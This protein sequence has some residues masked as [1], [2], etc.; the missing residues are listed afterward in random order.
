[1]LKYL[2]QN[3]VLGLLS[4]VLLTISYPFSGGITPL[5]FI[6]WIP[7]FVVALRLKEQE[8]G[9]FKFFLHGYLTTFVFNLGTTWWIWNSTAGGALMAFICNSLLM[10]IALT[11]GFAFFKRLKPG[12]FLAGIG[13]L[14]VC[15]EFLH[16]NWELSWPWLTM[17]NFFSIHPSW[18]QWYEY[19]G[20]LGGSFWVMAAN[21]LGALLLLNR[22]SVPYAVGLVTLLVFPIIVSF[23]RKRTIE[24]CKSPT[25]SIVILQPNIDPYTEKFNTDP[26]HQVESMLS[27]VRPYLHNTLAIGPETALQEAFIEKDFHQTRS[28][29]L[30]NESLSSTNSSLLIGASTFQLFDQKHSSASKSLPNGSFYESYNTALYM[31]DKQQQFIHKSKLV[32]GVE[33]IPFSRWLPFLEQLSIDNG[34]TSGSLG[35]ESEPKVFKTK[36]RSFAPIICYESIYGAFVAAQCKKGVELLCIITNDGWWGN[37]PGHRQHNQFAA[38]RAIET[39]KYV[40]RSGNTGISSIWNSH[41]ECLKQLEYDTK[42]VLT[43]KVPMLQGKTFYVQFGDYL[44]WVSVL[45]FLL[46]VSVRIKTQK[47]V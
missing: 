24:Q 35:V 5:V 15:F 14:W 3:I 27:L 34:G 40:V 16:F 1:M 11:I 29:K 46:L 30:L 25:Q 36:H 17:G 44:G 43:A 21:I 42:G 12:L 4:G 41:G 2:K 6:A 22:K 45:I 33:K 26:A 31:G 23:L 13:N 9:V 28:Y 32:L 37:T 39:R 20:T 47:K 10:A 19:T 8:R 38:L 18:V 7:L